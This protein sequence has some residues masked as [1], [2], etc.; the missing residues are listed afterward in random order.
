MGHERFRTIRIWSTGT[1]VIQEV[2]REL[3]TAGYVFA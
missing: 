1:F 3:E 2:F